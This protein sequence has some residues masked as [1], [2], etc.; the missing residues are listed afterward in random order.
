MWAHPKWTG[1]LNW[2]TNSCQKPLSW[3]LSKILSVDTPVSY[4]LPLPTW[5]ILMVFLPHLTCTLSL[6][7]ISLFPSPPLPTPGVS[8]L[9][10]LCPV[11]ISTDLTLSHSH[12]WFLSLA[13]MSWIFIDYT[14]PI[15]N[16]KVEKLSVFSLKIE[17]YI[18][19]YVTSLNQIFLLNDTMILTL[20]RVQSLIHFSQLYFPPLFP[21][22]WSISSH[23]LG[24]LSLLCHRQ[25]FFPPLPIGPNQV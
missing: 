23:F 6:T 15:Q 8:S 13:C 24:S 14:S 12:P 21:S 1:N 10:S 11:S 5:P 17:S 20:M 9:P 3:S 25:L 18:Y 7:C 4:F 22:F 16:L 2:P 19:H